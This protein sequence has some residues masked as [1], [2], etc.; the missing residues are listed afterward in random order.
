MLH[1][2]I[3]NPLVRL[4]PY[5]FFFVPGM[6]YGVTEL[7]AEVVNYISHATQQRLL[8]LLEK[9]SIVAQQRNV[10]FKVC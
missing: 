8:N 6:R 2:L 7:G 10:N 3:M 5:S 4:L 9:V 1:N